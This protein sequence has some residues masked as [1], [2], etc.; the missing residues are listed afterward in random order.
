[1]WVG[2]RS[3]EVAPSP[4]D[5]DHDVGDPEDLSVKSTSSGAVPDVGE[6]VKDVCNAGVVTVTVIDFSEFRPS[7]TAVRVT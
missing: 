7:V 3:V 4:N 6:A 1:M 2:C 5:H